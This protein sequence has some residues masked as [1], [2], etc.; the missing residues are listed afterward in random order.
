MP[1]GTEVQDVEAG[2]DTRLLVLHAVRLKGTAAAEVVA[3]NAGLLHHEAQ[4]ELARAEEEGLLEQRSG[5]LV[6][7]RLTARGR[8]AHQAL[9]EHDGRD[10]RRRAALEAAYAAFLPLNGR[11][12]DVCGRWQLL[13]DGRV[14][15][16]ADKEYDEQVVSELAALEEQAS[17]E[18][19]KAGA[20]CAR[21]T[22]YAERLH[23]ALR[24]VQ[25]GEHE[26]FARPMARSFH[27]AWM[28]LHQD[29]LLSLGRERDA[30]DGH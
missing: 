5:R 18:L 17:A 13:P 4:A 30:A 10:A 22:V 19:R 7:Y 26:A 15:E 8:E 9:L 21:L 14:N 23:G 28:E 11:L 24:R 20:D 29:L 6:G 1:V 16:H 2:S 25:A 3:E 12:K 27:D